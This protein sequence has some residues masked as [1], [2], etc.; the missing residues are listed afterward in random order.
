VKVIGAGFGRT[1]TTSLKAA[2]E[3]LG[4]GPC[5]HMMEVFA[6]PEHADWEGVL[7]GFEAT[8]D[9]P[10][11]TFYEELMERHPRRRCS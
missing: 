10:A 1:G 4:F 5:Y 8:V 7:G 11:C 6:H 2:L 9:W 3:E